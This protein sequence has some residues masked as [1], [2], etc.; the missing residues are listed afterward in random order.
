VAVINSN[1]VCVIV[2]SFNEATP[3]LNSVLE[4]ISEQN[5]FIVLI[6][7][8]SEIQLR[9]NLCGL[10]QFKGVLITHPVNLGQ[11][12]AIET[13]LEYARR[14][15]GS[16]DYV[17]T[18][19]ADGQHPVESIEPMILKMA[20]NQVDVILGTRFKPNKSFR[21]FRGGFAKYF[22]LK[23]AARMARLTFGI[24]VS[25]RHNGFRLFSSDAI[26]K[27]HITQ[28][29]F[30][31]ADEILRSIKHHKLTHQEMYVEISY[32]QYSKAKGQPLINAF[33]TIFD[34]F[35]GAR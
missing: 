13:G 1:R 11:G 27:F 23:F 10:G 3:V 7:D 8:G 9:H 5:Y 31:H 19:D 15:R 35:L 24:F 6:D 34:R 16:F 29:G 2:P 4:K 32:T 22:I 12:A 17:L 14:N 18:I 25:D 20:Q 26:G 30:G 28:N 21:D 33:Q